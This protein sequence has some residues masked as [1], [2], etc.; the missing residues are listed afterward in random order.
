M[1]FLKLQ[2]MLF[3]NF[4]LLGLIL[5]VLI[6]Y[7]YKYWAELKKVRRLQ[8][9]AEKFKRLIQS[10]S[11]GVVRFNGDGN[12]LSL[13]PAGA[14][15][16]WISGP[17]DDYHITEILTSH[18]VEMLKKALA[19]DRESVTVELPLKHITSE[20]RYITLS[21]HK[22]AEGGDTVYEG[23]FHDITEKVLLTKELY[24]HKHNLQ[25]LVRQKSDQLL[26][27]ARAHELELQSLNSKLAN[28]LE[29][30]RKRISQNLHDNVG[31]SLT[32][33]QMN[34]EAMDQIIPRKG[35]SKLKRVLKDNQKLLESVIEQIHETAV[36]LRPVILDELGL[37]PTLEWYFARF[38][39]R[40][41]IE[42]QFDHS[43]F[44]RKLDTA[45]AT[46]LYRI[47]QEALTNVVKHAEAG[48]IDYRLDCAKG[49]IVCSIRDD[50]RGFTPAAAGGA[51]PTRLGLAGIRER[52]DMFGGSFTVAS[53]RGRGTCLTISIPLEKA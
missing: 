4:F 24:T 43:D 11:E 21:L 38:V 9:V 48:R 17:P 26:V 12:V 7:L 30:E 6:L 19:N 22:Q 27:V 45:A 40:T 23:I 53:E 20:P 16:L 52:V 47:T 44:K 3:L 50:G 34:L 35:Q 2:R 39:Q 15:M 36:D 5:S 28:S 18:D 37:V 41:G 25:E 46:M 13:N 42:V 49:E 31:Q 14:K 51:D 32:A 10:T 8:I 33:I 29:E 1:E